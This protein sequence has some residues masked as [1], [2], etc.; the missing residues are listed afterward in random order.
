MEEHFNFGESLSDHPDIIIEVVRK[1]SLKS[2]EEQKSSPS[3]TNTTFE[4]HDFVDISV[5]FDQSSSTARESTSRSSNLIF[6]GAYAEEAPPPTLV[7]PYYQC[8]T[9]R[10]PDV[11]SDRPDK[12][13]RNSVQ[14]QDRSYTGHQYLP[15]REQVRA[16]IRDRQMRPEELRPCCC[17]LF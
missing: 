11:H 1:F 7:K 8:L 12:T 5:N 2:L 17:A 6:I 16:N 10:A 14:L 9:I 4:G 3:L 15:N 13:R